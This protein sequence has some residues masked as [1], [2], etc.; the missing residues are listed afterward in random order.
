MVWIVDAHCH[1]TDPRVF[2]QAP[3]ELARLIQAG[4]RGFLL[5][6][7]DPADWDRQTE[8][9]Q[10]FPSNV[11]RSFGLHP[12]FVAGKVPGPI[13]GSHR[14]ILEAA[15][16]RLHQEASKIDALGEMG[17]DFRRQFL[18]AGKDIQIEYFAKQL[19][20]AAQ[21]GKPVVLH[22]VRAHE[23]A[24]AELRRVRTRATQ[25]MVHAFTA[26]PKVARRY[27]DLG[28]HLS[29]GA[30]LLRP[31]THDLH[32]TVAQ[33]PLE[34]LLIESDCPDQPPPG[35]KQHDSSTVWRVAERVSDLKRLPLEEI[36][37]QT[38]ANLLH[39]MQREIV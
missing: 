18:P 9:H 39:L 14:A 15:F 20:L 1:W 6:G 7:V 32:D 31:E 30:A 16:N 25:G 22:I 11:F 35:L 21:T 33:M 10:K 37:K 4:L 34:R 12:Y 29:I 8:L 24:L 2:A 5:G 36:V 19:D 26:G 28:Y 23:E 3:A 17:L 13:C 27:L 38:R